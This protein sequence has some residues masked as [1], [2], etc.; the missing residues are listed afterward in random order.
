MTITWHYQICYVE[1]D[2]GIVTI[3]KEDMDGKVT[4]FGSGKCIGR[5]KGEWATSIQ[6]S[7]GECALVVYS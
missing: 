5:R 4:M 7:D 6:E 1:I 2:I 3:L